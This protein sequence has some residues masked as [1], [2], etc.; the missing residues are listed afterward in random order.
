M[1]SLSSVVCIATYNGMPFVREQIKSILAQTFVVNKIVIADDASSDGTQSAILDFECSSIQLH[2]FSS[3]IGHVRNFERALSYCSSDVIFLCDQDDVWAP[4]KVELVLNVF[5]DNPDVSLVCHGSSIIG[6]ECDLMSEKYIQLIHG[7]QPTF[8]FMIYELFQPRIY[9][10]TMAFR[11]SVL[12]IALPFPSSVYA[13]DHWVAFAASV[14]GNIYYIDKK[15]VSHRWHDSNLTPRARRNFRF[16]LRS[17]CILL[18]LLYCACLRR[19]LSSACRI[20]IN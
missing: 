2:Q 9:G 12:N 11:R 20:N 13:H 15:L 6:R 1:N 14:I 16:V 7:K 3:N 17:R 18:I 10:C 8:L 19:L 4:E 5:R